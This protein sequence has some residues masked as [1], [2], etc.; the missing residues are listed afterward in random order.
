M[1]GWK[2][3]VENEPIVAGDCGESRNRTNDI[4]LQAIWLIF[5]SY[6]CQI[7]KSQNHSIIIQSKLT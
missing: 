4:W 1:D 5:H 6:I 2:S 3:V 7:H